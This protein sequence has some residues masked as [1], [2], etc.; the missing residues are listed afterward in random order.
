MPHFN[1]IYTKLNTHLIAHMEV[2][3]QISRKHKYTDFVIQ[4]FQALAEIY[5]LETEHF[6]LSQKTNEEL[7]LSPFLKLF[8]PNEEIAHQL[9]KRSVLIKSIIIVNKYTM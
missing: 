1:Y 3:V 8:I 5:N 9:I 7:I 2:L 4:E 6:F